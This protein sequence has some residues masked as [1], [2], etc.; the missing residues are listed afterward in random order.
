MMNC[1]DPSTQS[2]AM[3]CRLCRGPLSLSFRER[4]LNKYPVGY[5]RCLDCGSMQTDPPHWLEESYSAPRPMTDT[6]MVARSIQMAQM[7]SLLLRIAS[8]GAQTKC[9]DWGGG[10]GLFC[11][12][13]R[14]Q[15]YNFFNDDKYAKPFYCDGF[16]FQRAG[17]AKCDILTSFE[18]FEHLANPVVELEE[19]LSLE[20]RLWIFSTQLYEQQGPEWNYF[21]PA[22]GQ[23]VF[24]YSAQGLEGFATAH[25]YRFIRGR[26]LH[27]FVKQT[28][29]PYLQN[30]ISLNCARKVLAGGK[31][32]G[33]VAGLNFLARQRHAFR[34]W[35]ADRDHVRRL[36]NLDAAGPGRR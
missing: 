32:A 26:H 5:W 23:H 30:R 14:D 34:H 33:L 25:G 29:S 16:T 18:I 7:T 9:L 21:G 17:I 12:M 35:Q 24:F 15:G 27:A 11:R 2:E 4:V 6:G 8:V 31:L 22:N 36:A 28:G 3:L 20:P 10:N 1:Q 13:M 19:I